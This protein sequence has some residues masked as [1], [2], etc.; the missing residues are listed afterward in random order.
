MKR[1]FHF[2]QTAVVGVVAPFP[3]GVAKSCVECRASTRNPG[4]CSG[5]GPGC[6]IAP[7]RID[8]SAL[9]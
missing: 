3:R 1:P 2:A 5:F 9:R 6:L 8:V 7:R 4:P